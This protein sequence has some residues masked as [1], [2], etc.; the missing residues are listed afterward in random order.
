[1]F[2]L[3]EDSVL[4]NDDKRRKRF[5]DFSPTPLDEAVKETLD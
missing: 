4:L 3:Y 2:Y 1:M 5:P